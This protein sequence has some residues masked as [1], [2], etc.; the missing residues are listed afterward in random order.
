MRHGQHDEDHHLHSL[1]Y[2]HWGE[3]KV[4][5]GVPGSHASALEDAM[6]KNLPDLFEEQ[7]HLLNELVIYLF[8]SSLIK[9]NF[10]FLEISQN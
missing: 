1:N 9:I 10:L 8:C 5:Y 7:P 3:P 4:W 6:R 2:H